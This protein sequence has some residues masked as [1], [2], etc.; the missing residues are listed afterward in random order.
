M[1]TDDP[2]LT[3]YALGEPFLSNDP[4]TDSRLNRAFVER[5]RITSVLGV[6][7]RIKR[8]LIGFI[9][10]GNRAGGFRRRDMRLLEIF[11][12]QAAETIVNARLFL[13]IQAQAER[14]AVVNRLL[15]SLQRG[16]E[17]K[18]KIHSVIERV[19]Q[20]LDLD[21]CIVVLFAEGEDEDY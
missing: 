6:P 21:R 13:T 9:C 4:A 1:K 2:R 20:V 11:S 18:E 3:A 12:A 10:V 8:E 17:P 14:E 15:L 16:G 7:M 19:G 5:H